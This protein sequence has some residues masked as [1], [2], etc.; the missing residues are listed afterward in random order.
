VHPIERLR[1]VARASGADQGLLVREAAGA[2]A[3]FRADP[4]GLVTACRS[5]LARQPAVG[6]LWWLCARV[7]CASD[8]MVEAWAAADEIDDDPTARE[9]GH[10][11]ADDATVCLIGWPELTAAGL[12]RRGDVSSLVVDAL[13][14]GR[15]LVRRLRDA[16]CDA[17]DVAP[18]GAAAA[19][20]A[21]DLVLL[22]AGAAGPGGFVAVPGSRAAAAT[23]HHAGVPVWLVAGRGRML[24]GPLW[25]ALAARVTGPTPWAADDEVVPLDLVDRVVGPR[26]LLVPADA[27]ATTDCPVVAELLSE[28]S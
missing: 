26:G 10:L 24:P 2:L 23:A 9:L 4:Q 8:P 12:C 15:G 21:A 14:E 3:H 18:E 20:A 25:D 1:F 13:G 28:P 16:G 17:H 19:A 7:L 6:G 22:E 27:V 5:V 11:L